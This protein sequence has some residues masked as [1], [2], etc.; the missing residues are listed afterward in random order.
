MSYVLFHPGPL[1]LSTY[2]TH[3]RQQISSKVGEVLHSQCR[4][5]ADASGHGMKERRTQ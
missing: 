3:I 4:L 5:I 2:Q 1:D